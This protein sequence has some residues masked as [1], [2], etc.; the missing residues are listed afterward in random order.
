MTAEGLERAAKLATEN[1]YY[2]PRRVE[3]QGVRKLLE[4]AF[5]GRR[6]A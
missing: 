6:P 4:D 3:Y 2:N 1:P 5:D